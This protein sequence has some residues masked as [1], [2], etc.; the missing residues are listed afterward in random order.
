MEAVKCAVCGAKSAEV[1]FEG[2]DLWYGIEG[3]FPV[4]QCCSCG[5]IYLS[6]RPERGE[7]DRYYPT[8]Y[9]PYQMAEDDEPSRW[10]R[11]NRRYSESKKVRAVQARVAS[12]GNALDIGC[13]TGDFLEALRRH[14]WDVAGV[15]TNAEAANYAVTR[16]GLDVYTGEL[17]EA[18][19][20]DSRFDLVTMWHVLEHV[21]DPLATLEEVARITRPGGTVLLAIPDPDSLE[22]HLFGQCWAG[23]DVPRHLHIFSRPLITRLLQERGWQVRDVVYMTGRH[24][25]FNLS[26]RHWSEHNIG[27]DRIRRLLLRIAGSL[28]ARLLTLPVFVLLE[29]LQKGSIMVLFAARAS[30]DTV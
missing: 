13:A 16:F 11:W 28:P 5:L 17:Q 26:L 19:F 23:W 6:P 8:E 20:P 22:A 9:A 3:R 24:W 14:G 1:L 4:R 12:T 18:D 15:E 29:R 25:L 10:R 27:S 2:R 21:H 7:I 30:G